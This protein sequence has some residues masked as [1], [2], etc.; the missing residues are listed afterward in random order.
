MN[1]LLDPIKYVI[2]HAEH[3]QIDEQAIEKYVANFQETKVD[4]WMKACPFSYHA[5]PNMEDEIDRWFLADAMAFCFWGY[6]TKWTVEY[7]SQK[8]DGWWALLAALQCNLEKKTELLDGN[9]LASMSE[10]EARVLLAGVPEIPLLKE[11]LMAFRDIGTVLV[12]K[13]AGRFHNFLKSSPTDGTEFIYALAKE[14]PIFQDVSLY[15]GIDVPFYKKAQLLAHDLVV[16][17]P[18]SPYA[19]LTG[20]DELT[21]EADYKVP[22]LLRKFG[23]L[24][25]SKE[26]AEKVDKRIE[27]PQDSLEEIE[28]RAGMLWTCHLICE[29]LK[30]KKINLDPINLD[31]ILWV[32]SQTKSG[33]DKP[34][35]L[36]L[37]TNY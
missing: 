24:E 31:G 16:G 18:N 13:Y 27:L 30:A 25:Y 12:A 1:K 17:F 7:Q 33:E 32:Q 4:H 2:D 34:Y 21:G 3:V 36:T 14:F 9:Y 23:I 29:K 6:P 22:A 19:R 11:R 28:I 35:H 5:L 15:K 26:L 8:I 20:I 37:T 10:A